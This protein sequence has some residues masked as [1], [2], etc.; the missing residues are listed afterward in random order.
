MSEKA[1]ARTQRLIG[2]AGVVNLASRHVLIAGLGGVG[3]HVA[4]ALA[5][6][7]VGT[8][9]LVDDDVVSPSDLNRQII[10]L[11]STLGRDKVDVCAQRILDIN[12]ELE[13]RLKPQRIGADNARSLVEETPVDFV[14]DC[15]DSVRDKAA[16]LAACLETD[17][18]VISS[19]G[20]AGR[21]DPTRVGITRLNRTHTDGLA[22]AVRKRLKELG[23]A[24]RVPV[25]FSDELPRKN[26]PGNAGGGTLSYMPAV[27]GLMQAGYIVRELLGDRGQ[28]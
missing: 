15:I 14:A 21:L 26:G 17:T 12:S 13:L 27:F 7:G 20:S 16:L 23:V 1:C 28:L 8:L 6:A 5:R 19:M 24:P 22:R 2:R 4:E 11:Q 25:V 9:T 3:G 18:A 10:A